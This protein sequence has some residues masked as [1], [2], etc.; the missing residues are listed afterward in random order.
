MQVSEDEY[1]HD[2]Y[3]A[4]RGGGNGLALSIDAHSGEVYEGMGKE[5]GIDTLLLVKKQSN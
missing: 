2:F 5:N 3:F 1:G 4:A